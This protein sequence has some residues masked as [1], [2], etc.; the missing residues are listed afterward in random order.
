MKDTGQ[1]LSS[2]SWRIV[3]RTLLIINF[4]LLVILVGPGNSRKLYLAEK[5]LG[6]A[7][8]IVHSLQFW[9][10][11]S[12]LFVTVLFAGLVISKSETLRSQRPTKLDWALF[13]CWFVLATI[14]ISLAFMTGMG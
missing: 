8:M 2:R 9:F 12:T 14:V 11:V 3:L 4:T 7:D 5:R 1:T 6:V 13:L 10:V